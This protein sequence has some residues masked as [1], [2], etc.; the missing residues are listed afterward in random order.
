MPLTPPQIQRFRDEGY[1]ILG[2]LVSPERVTLLREAFDACGEKLRRE[3][4]F[5]NTRHVTNEQGDELGVYQIRAA[6][7]QHPAFND[8]VRD[9]AL[10][11]S[12]EQIIGPNIRLCLMQG[13]Y[14]PPHRG[15][16]VT[17]HQDDRYFQV[18]I[19]DA[20][21]SCWFAIDEATIDNGCMWVLPRHHRTLMPHVPT[22]DKKGYELAS[23]DESTAVACEL[24]AGHA[25]FHH[26]LAPHRSLPNTTD[27]PRR[28]V[29]MHFMSGA[30]RPLGDN[31]MAEPSENMPVVRGTGVKW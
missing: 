25:M 6:H 22:L 27:R 20:V 5:T 15:A 10:L 3:G 21:V 18:D 16:A 9:P 17:W 26:G 13:L 23:V 8:L 24:P 1:L 28:A 30:A 4:K 19:P 7:L 29:A 31:R 12:V 11:D 14:K 2:R